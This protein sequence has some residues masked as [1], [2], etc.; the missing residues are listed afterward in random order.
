[1]MTITDPLGED[2]G[3]TD[4]RDR[5]Y[6]E[7]LVQLIGK[8]RTLNPLHKGGELELGTSKLPVDTLHGKMDC[9]ARAKSATA[10][11][12]K[13]RKQQGLQDFALDAPNTQ[14]APNLQDK[15]PAK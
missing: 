7:N 6:I 4:P 12:T 13:F 5:T 9:E 1:M 10:L 14:D 2:A 11:G 3:L 8:T 15:S